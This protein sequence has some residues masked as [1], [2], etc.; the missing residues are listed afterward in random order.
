[1]AVGGATA[2]QV[3]R[4]EVVDKE[5]REAEREGREEKEDGT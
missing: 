4:Q 5:G 1:M 3:H 2:P